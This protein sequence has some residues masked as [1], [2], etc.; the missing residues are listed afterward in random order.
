[1]REGMTITWPNVCAWR[2]GMA[3]PEPDQA[4]EVKPLDLCM[5]HIAVRA[6][7]DQRR[8]DGTTVA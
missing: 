1:M 2:G 4:P 8:E 3:G 7:A 6:G 5:E